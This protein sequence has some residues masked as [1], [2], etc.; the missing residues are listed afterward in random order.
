MEIKHSTIYGHLT[1]VSNGFVECPLSL[2]FLLLVCNKWSEIK[3]ARG[4]K[5]SPR[6][7]HSCI[8]LDNKYL[9]IIG[10]M[11]PSSNPPT[12]FD[13]AHILEIGMS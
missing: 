11:S 9:L 13:S 4:P 10:G 5:P 2:I 7:A 1:L 3:D 8:S 6:C 12:V